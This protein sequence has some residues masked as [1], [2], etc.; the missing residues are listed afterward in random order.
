MRQTV[1]VMLIV[2]AAGQI[3]T[4]APLDLDKIRTVMALR[5]VEVYSAPPGQFLTLVTDPQGHIATLSRDQ[6][7]DVIEVKQIKLIGHNDIWMK[8][9]LTLDGGPREG[10]VLYGSNSSQEVNFRVTREE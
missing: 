4:A 7:V 2:C 8:I 6:V 9:Q 3:G 10:W 1:F 5:P